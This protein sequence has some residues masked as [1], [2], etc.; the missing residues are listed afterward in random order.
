MELSS[1]THEYRLAPIC[2]RL[3]KAPQAAFLP[4]HRAQEEVRRGAK[5]HPASQLR[6]HVPARRK[7]REPANAQRF[8][9]LQLVCTSKL[10]S[11]AQA[12]R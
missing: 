5:A 1:N 2:S 7:H 12:C 3:E 8:T 11:S 4:S 6:E 10:S 9:P